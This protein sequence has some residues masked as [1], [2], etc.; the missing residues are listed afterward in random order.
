M[1]TT[2]YTYTSIA[3]YTTALLTSP[4]L[5]LASGNNRKKSSNVGVIVALIVLVVLILITITI[6]V[7]GISIVRKAKKSMQCNK[8]EGIYYST[9]DETNLQRTTNNQPEAPHSELTDMQLSKEEPQYME[10]FKNTSGLPMADKVKMQDNP[11]YSL[12]SDQFK[13]QDNPAY[14]S[15]KI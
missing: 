14:A 10:I 11:S 9:I 3:T 12:S 7:I 4:T 5:R 8:P 6:F 1:I 13:M 15:T 2:T